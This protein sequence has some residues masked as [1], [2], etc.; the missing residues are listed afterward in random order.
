MSTKAVGE[1]LIRYC[2]VLENGQECI[3]YVRSSARLTMQSAERVSFLVC[4]VVC[5]RARVPRTAGFENRFVD[6]VARVHGCNV[7]A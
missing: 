2:L 3:Q 4:T 5:L 1:L 7:S 6:D